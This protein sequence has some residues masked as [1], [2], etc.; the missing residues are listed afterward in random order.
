MPSPTR[1][2]GA[3]SS[4]IHEIADPNATPAQPARQEP[5]R[6]SR[7]RQND[8]WIAAIKRTLAPRPM[9]TS[10]SLLGSVTKARPMTARAKLGL[11]P[12]EAH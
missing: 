11:A 6:P 1:L 3:S 10:S 9:T 2:S 7:T 8:G 5:T 12:E 4:D